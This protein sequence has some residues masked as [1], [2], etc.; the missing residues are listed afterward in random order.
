MPQQHIKR[1]PASLYGG[2]VIALVVFALW[3]LILWEPSAT[4]VVI[5][6][7]V[8]GAIGIWTRLANL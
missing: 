8:A 5:G 7:I 6:A 3:T 1:S 2:I 4:Q